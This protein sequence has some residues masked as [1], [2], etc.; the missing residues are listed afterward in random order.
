MVLQKKKKLNI[1]KTKRDQMTE[2]SDGENINREKDT[3]T[4]QRLE[5]AIRED[6]WTEDTRWED[7]IAALKVIRQFELESLFSFNHISVNQLINSKDRQMHT[8]G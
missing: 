7:I 3:A 2:W 1:T 4:K 6:H 5:V 8:R